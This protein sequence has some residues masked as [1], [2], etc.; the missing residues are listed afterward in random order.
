MASVTSS[1]F[2]TRSFFRATATTPVTMAPR[3]IICKCA[4]VSDLQ[5]QKELAGGS[6]LAILQERLKC[7]TFCG[8][9]VPDLKRMAAEF[10]TEET[11][12]A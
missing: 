9:C 8:S 7:G 10:K 11:A 1:L 6:S 5:I 3:N 12:P 4:D 2:L